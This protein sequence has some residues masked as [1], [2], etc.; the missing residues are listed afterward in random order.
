MLIQ[1]GAKVEEGTQVAK[2]KSQKVKQAPPPVQ[3]KPKIN[4]KKIPKRY[5][6][7]ILKDGIYEPLSE[8][9]WMRFQELNP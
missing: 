1:Y 3:P 6:L 7:T 5:Q 9:E 4:E 2:N 8:E